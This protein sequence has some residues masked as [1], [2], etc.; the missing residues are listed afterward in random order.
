MKSKI[1][2]SENKPRVCRNK[3]QEEHHELSGTPLTQSSVLSPQSSEPK[4]FNFTQICTDLLHSGKLVRFK[5]PGHSMY[6]TIL[7]G[8][9]ITVEPIRPKAVKVGD[10]VLYQSEVNLTA[11]RVVR[12]KNN[13][14]PRNDTQSSALSPQYCF[15]L[16][17]DARPACDAPV[18]A[19]QILG[20]VVLIESNGRL[21]DPYGFKVKIISIVRRFASGLK[22]SLIP[23]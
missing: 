7:N 17:G 15:I 23:V 5:A 14:D 3:I 10:I 20:K 4:V 6:P 1:S 22:R 19:E 21:I 16:R 11:H 13:G 9:E 18:A 12:I 8:D 2:I